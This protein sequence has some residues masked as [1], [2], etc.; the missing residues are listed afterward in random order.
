MTELDAHRDAFDASAD[1]FDLTTEGVYEIES[2]KD[3]SDLEGLFTEWLVFDRKQT[4]WNDRSG[5]EQFVVVNPL[6]L[7]RKD[8]DA[9][10]D[11]LR[12]EVGLF[13]VV[14]ISPGSHVVV[15]SLQSGD[16]R[17]VYDVSASMSLREGDTLWTRVAPVLGVYHMV[18]SMMIPLPIRFGKEMREDI[19]SWEQ[20][21]WDAHEAA[22]FRYGKSGSSPSARSKPTTK[23]E[24]QQKFE[25]ALA[26]CGMEEF[27]TMKR[28]AAWVQNEEKYGRNFPAKVFAFLV[29]EDIAPEK[30]N[31]LLEAGSAFSN[32]IPRKQLGGLTPSAV[33]ELEMADPKYNMETYSWATYEGELVR[34]HE[35]MQGGKAKEAYGIFEATVQRLLD[36]RIPAF[37]SFRIFANAGVACMMRDDDEGQAIGL[38]GELFEASLRINPQYDFGIRSRQRFLETYADVSHVPKRDR[39]LA[40]DFFMLAQYAG[41]LMYRKTA[42]YKYEK[43]LRDVGITLSYATQTKPTAWR[44]EE[45]GVSRKIGRNDPCYCGSGKKFKKCCG[46]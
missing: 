12:F 29:P 37:P 11:M 10:T 17:K 33:V 25:E 21:S 46:R 20:N 5:L 4:H 45:D 22:K 14:G 41:R 27:F 3:E 40:R 23:K 32:L 9:Y 6:G 36:N 18:G 30:V 35:L 15:E 26:A 39:T 19:R 2:A 31:T 16:V 38:G 7:S 1:A 42:F 13:E 8:M 44:V 24:A 43:F 34:A 28:F